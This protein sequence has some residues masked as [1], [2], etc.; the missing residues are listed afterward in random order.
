MTPVTGLPPSSRWRHA[1]VFLFFLWCAL[2]VYSVAAPLS[3]RAQRET[4]VTLVSG[5]MAPIY[6]TGS[7]LVLQPTD[8]A[9][10][11]QVG[12]VI[13]AALGQGLPL[14]HRVVER[15]MLPTGVAFRTQGDANDAADSRLVVPNQVLGRI[16][17][18]VPGWMQPALALQQ[19]WWRL[20]LF[21]VPLLL[22]MIGELRDV[23]RRTAAR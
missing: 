8:A 18:P 5:S 19:Q 2:A 3:L 21:G 1:A 15:V 17:G 22:I 13:T 11:V 23:R 4:L 6:P 10:E 12:D 9:R 14:T 16:A 7:T 20:V